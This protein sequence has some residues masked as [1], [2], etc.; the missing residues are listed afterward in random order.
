LIYG[1]YCKLSLFKELLKLIYNAG[2]QE[3]NTDKIIPDK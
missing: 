2:N 3:N 1:I